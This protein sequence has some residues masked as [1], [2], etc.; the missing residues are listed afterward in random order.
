MKYAIIL[1]LTLSGCG[2][3]YKCI[4]GKTYTQL[5]IGSSIYVPFGQTKDVPC[6]VVNP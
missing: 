1:C 2:D 3:P 5:F 6:T 4:D